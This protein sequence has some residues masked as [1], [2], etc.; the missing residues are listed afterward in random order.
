[1]RY[2]AHIARA[3]SHQAGKCSCNSPSRRRTAIR[4]G[5]A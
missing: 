2:A 4:S 1:M 3:P 5:V